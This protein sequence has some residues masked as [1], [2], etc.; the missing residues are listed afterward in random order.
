MSKKNVTRIGVGLAAGAVAWSLAVAPVAVAEVYPVWARGTYRIAGENRYETS[1]QLSFATSVAPQEVVY[2]ASGEAFADA[3]AA[4]PAAHRAEAPLL[5]VG[6]NHLPDPI[7]DELLRLK[8][9]TIRIV[10]GTGAVSDA[11]LDSVRTLTGATVERVAGANRYETAA[12]LAGGVHDVDRLYVVSGERYEDAV[13][14]G[15]LAGRDRSALVLVRKDELPAVSKQLLKSI[16]SPHI[17]VVGGTEA[18]SEATA[19]AVNEAAGWVALDRVA[20]AD[21]YDTSAQLYRKFW[22]AGSDVLFYASGTSYPDALS[23]SRVAALSGA[24]VLLT[25][26]E[27]HPEP[28]R[29]LSND[30]VS[31]VKVTVG[32]PAVA[33]VEW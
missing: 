22:G 14:A 30:L 27:G 20:G 29:V 17:A 19:T 7:A 23:A 33:A 9:A 12:L 24:P 11:V 8:P 32:G 28:V 1:A 3:L 2:L 6:K 5:L 15:A 25:T 13:S 10:G 21:R 18:V 31:N 4:G 26:A 16:R